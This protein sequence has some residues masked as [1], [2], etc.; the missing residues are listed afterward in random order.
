MSNINNFVANHIIN[1]F[2]SNLIITS[3]IYYITGIIIR[4]LFEYFDI[5][6]GK[7]SS[8]R[9]YWFLLL[10]IMFIK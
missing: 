4:F 7:K 10:C 8:S 6:C 2:I 3:F 1:N 9:I 5:W